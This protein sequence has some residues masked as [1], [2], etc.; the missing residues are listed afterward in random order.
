MRHDPDF[1]F[2]LA[3]DEGSHHGEHAL[4]TAS[5]ALHFDFAAVGFADHIPHFRRHAEADERAILRRHVPVARLRTGNDPLKVI[6]CTV[7]ADQIIGN[8]TQP[9][10]IQDRF[11]DPGT[12]IRHGVEHHKAAPGVRS[13]KVLIFR[14]DPGDDPF[15]RRGDRTVDQMERVP[16]I[17]RQH[18]FPAGAIA[19]VGSPA[20]SAAH[21]RQF[22]HGGIPC[23]G[24][25]LI[26]IDRLSVGR[27]FQQFH[28]GD[29]VFDHEI[30]HELT[31]F[32]LSGGGLLLLDRH[33]FD[34]IFPEKILI[35]SGEKFPIHLFHVQVPVF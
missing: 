4:V 9:A 5:V 17:I 30:P 31:R 8:D 6:G 23:N 32:V 13:G 27:K 33:Q 7:S 11:Q 21:N 34:R 2:A 22:P 3:G 15:R 20:G 29:A 24:H 26:L 28:I 19:P 1:L 18:T 14:D 10:L 16:L 35:D 12:G 25:A